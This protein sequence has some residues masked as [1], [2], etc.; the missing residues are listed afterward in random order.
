VHNDVRV[1]STLEVARVADVNSK[2]NYGT[3]D[4]TRKVLWGQHPVADDHKVNGDAADD[5][6]CV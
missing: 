5:L 6:R 2:S 3:N 1:S 4:H